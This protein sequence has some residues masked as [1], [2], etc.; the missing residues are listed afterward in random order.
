MRTPAAFSVAAEERKWPQLR[1]NFRQDGSYGR[2][3][4]VKADLGLCVKY[5]NRADSLWS[6]YS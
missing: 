1:A 5:A 3:L 6:G 2:G 4:P